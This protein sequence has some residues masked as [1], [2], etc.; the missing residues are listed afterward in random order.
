MYNFNIRLYQLLRYFI[1]QIKKLQK[2][3]LDGSSGH[4]KEDAKQINSHFP[5]NI[6]S[7][8]RIRGSNTENN[9]RNDLIH[10]N[11]NTKKGNSQTLKSIAPNLDPI[12]EQNYFF[13]ALNTSRL[14]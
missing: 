14:K 9:Q 12:N 11:I 4:I 7:I 1:R 3:L 2:W 6:V 8:I 5:G 10:K 13:L